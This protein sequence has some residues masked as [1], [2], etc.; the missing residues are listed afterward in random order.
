MRKKSGISRLILNLLAAA[1]IIIIL[2]VG[3]RWYEGRSAH[4]PETQDGNRAESQVSAEAAAEGEETAEAEVSAEAAAEGKET[5][6]AEVP[7]EAAAAEE[8]TAAAG[9]TAAEVKSSRNFFEKILVDLFGSTGK[10]EEMSRR[11]GPAGKAIAET[12]AGK[13]VSSAATAASSVKDSLLKTLMASIPEEEIPIDFATLWETCPDVYAWIRIP[14]TNIDYPVC[15]LAEGDQSFYLNHRPDGTPEF[16]GSIYAENY[17]SAD[18]KDPVTVFYGHDMSDGSMFQN[19]HKY[20]EQGFF[21][22]NREV[23]VYLP[24]KV[25]HYRIFA[26]YNTDN[27]HLLVNNGSFQ[28]PKVFYEYFR[29]VL[30]GNFISGL[31]DTDTVLTPASRILTLSTCNDYEDQ[32]YLVQ[33]VLTNPE[34]LQKGEL[35][36]GE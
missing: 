35:Y 19:L 29:E 16:A 26:A 14:D 17:N 12:A 15:R 34:V 30:K 4:R 24:D 11:A 2:A 25:L 3:V 23:T 33:C 18:F 1:A 9:E 28:D 36:G 8:E 13:M 22:N 20:E 21:D 10:E 32:R 27:G 5:A 6:E 7:A 31:V